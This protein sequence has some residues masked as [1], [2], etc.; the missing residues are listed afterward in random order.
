[1]NNFEMITIDEAR[2]YSQ[3]H[4]YII[5]DLR[6]EEDYSRGHIENA[7]NIPNANVE[8]INKYRKKQYV[9]ILYCNRGSLSFKLAKEMSDEGYTV[10]A[11]VG[12]YR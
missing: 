6:K 3:I 2:K 7:I 8:Q 9:W 5:A 4:G 11:V 12:G 10:L 1:M